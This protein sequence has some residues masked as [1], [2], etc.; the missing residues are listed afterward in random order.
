MSNGTIDFQEVKYLSSLNIRFNYRVEPYEALDYT[1]GEVVV[2]RYSSVIYVQNLSEDVQIVHKA[3]THFCYTEFRNIRP[4]TQRKYLSLLKRFLNY[5]YFDSRA[6][7][8]DISRLTIEHGKYFLNSLELNNNDDEVKICSDLLK[9][10]YL[11]FIY[12]KILSIDDKLLHCSNPFDNDSGRN[13]N[14]GEKPLHYIPLSLVIL[15]FDIA[16]CT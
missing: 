16:V 1:T 7:I 12:L 6:K 5:I 13:P 15:F 9:K 2:E 8:N 3:F 4:S 10:L 14:Q 11:H